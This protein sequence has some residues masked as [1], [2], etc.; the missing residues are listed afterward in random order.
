M[1]ENK[2]EDIFKILNESKNRIL[3]YVQSAVSCQEQYQAVRKLILDELGLKGA[4]HRIRK[5]FGKEGGDSI[6]ESEGV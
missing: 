2:L 6:E 3:L 1:T 4:E 5:L